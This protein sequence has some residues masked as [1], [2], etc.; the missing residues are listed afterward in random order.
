MQRPRLD[1]AALD[2]DLDRIVDRLGIVS[3]GVHAGREGEQRDHTFDG[4]EAAPEA[5]L[6]GGDDSAPG[7]IG[8]QAEVDHRG[9]QG[10]R[11]VL[12]PRAVLAGK[13]D[14]SD[15]GCALGRGD[16]RQPTMAASR[17]PIF[18]SAA[19]TGCLSLTK[20]RMTDRA[21]LIEAVRQA[22]A[23][24]DAARKLSE[25]N[26]AARR[27]QRARE[28]LRSAEAGTPIMRVKKPRADPGR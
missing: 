11:A 9:D 5:E 16:R 22:E 12:L 18:P 3:K 1:P 6:M 23:E 7:G 24:L 21:R 4:V 10:S 13:L 20:E 8:T 26:A 15:Q 25:I 19:K 17:S 28:E 2:G 27:L 14:P